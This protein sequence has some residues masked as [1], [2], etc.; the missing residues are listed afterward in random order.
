MDTL[1][2]SSNREAPACGPRDVRTRT[3]KIRDANMSAR[4]RRL[5]GGG[6]SRATGAR[7][8]GSPGCATRGGNPGSPG[9]TTRGGCTQGGGASGRRPRSRCGQPQILLRPPLSWRAK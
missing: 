6:P 1:K 4:D 3:P 7:H 8:K 5:P 9:Y 2:K